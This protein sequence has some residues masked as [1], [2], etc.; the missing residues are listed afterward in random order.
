MVNLK[1]I[2]AG[3]VAV[4]LGILILPGAGFLPIIGWIFIFSGIFTMIKGGLGW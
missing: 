1:E 2:V 3:F 4:V